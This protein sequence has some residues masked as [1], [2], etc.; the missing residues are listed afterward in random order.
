[1]CLT[2]DVIDH[3][4]RKQQPADPPAKVWDWSSG[5]VRGVNRGCHETLLVCFEFS[6][7]S[8]AARHV[9]ESLDTLFFPPVRKR[10]REYTKSSLR[11]FANNFIWK[12]QLTATALVT[13]TRFVPI[14]IV[15]VDQNFE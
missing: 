14:T 3:C 6:D 10:T 1:E 15:Q 9:F 12:S 11:E 5:S 8:L 7:E 4:R 2:V 13:L